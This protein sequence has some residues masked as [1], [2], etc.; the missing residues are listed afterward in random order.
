MLWNRNRC[1]RIVRYGRWKMSSLHRTTPVS[2]PKAPNRVFDLFCE[3]LKRFV[4]D[5]PLIN[6][7][8]KTRW[9]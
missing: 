2:P 4:S 8:D 7:V 1:R 6:V 9:Y 3:N 5:E